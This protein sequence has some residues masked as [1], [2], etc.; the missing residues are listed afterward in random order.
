MSAAD[1]PRLIVYLAG[2]LELNKAAHLELNDAAVRLTRGTFA[3]FVAKCPKAWPDAPPVR[4]R[5]RLARVGLGAVVEAIGDTAGE[6]CPSNAAEE[7]LARRA[8]QWADRLR[9][10]EAEIQQALGSEGEAAS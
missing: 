3:V 7:V 1:S 8:L 5:V 4:A 9:E 6:P 10:V 2:G